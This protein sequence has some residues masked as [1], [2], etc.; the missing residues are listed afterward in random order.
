MEF[1]VSSS[2]KGGSVKGCVICTWGKM[3][4]RGSYKQGGGWD[5]V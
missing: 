4:W 2:V 1:C 5:L 3:E